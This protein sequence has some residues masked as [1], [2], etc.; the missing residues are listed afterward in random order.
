MVRT[1][2]IVCGA[3]PASSGAMLL[4]STKVVLVFIA[5]VNIR[6][7]VAGSKPGKSTTA[8]RS[9]SGPG[10]PARGAP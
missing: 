5:T 10:C 7:S 8:S 6:R 9:S 4:P 3:R 2:N 1:P